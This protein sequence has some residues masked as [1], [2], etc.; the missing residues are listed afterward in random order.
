MPEI[1]PACRH[2]AGIQ[3]DGLLVRP[4]PSEK[5]PSKNALDVRVRER[6]P[7]A[8]G[9]GRDG[10]RGV[11]ADAGQG[12]E[13][14]HGLGQASRR[15]PRDPVQISGAAVV[16]EARPFAEH[17][18]ERRGGQGPERG[19][20]PDESVER[21]RDPRGLGLLQHHLGDEHLVRIARPAPR[22]I[23][24]GAAVVGQKPGADRV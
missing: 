8:E 14:G 10:P 1:G 23:P 12:I 9:E 17:G 15:H 7:L 5:E 18:T 13:L 4:R 6:D 11:R 3:L 24:R 2:R 16:A 20:A 21:R 19:K 22:Q